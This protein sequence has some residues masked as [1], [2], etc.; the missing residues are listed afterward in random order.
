MFASLL[1]MGIFCV[2]YY[3]EQFCYLI[4]YYFLSIFV[5]ITSIQLILT[6]LLFF[7]N[8]ISMSYF[9]I[10]AGGIVI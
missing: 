1:S 7:T 10:V 4:F 8:L 2:H 9:D 6:V 3:A 5:H